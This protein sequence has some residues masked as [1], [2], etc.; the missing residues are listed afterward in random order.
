MSTSKVGTLT[1]G[2]HLERSEAE[3]K[4]LLRD[5]TPTTHYLLSALRRFLDK[6]RMTMLHT[7]ATHHYRCG[8]TNIQNYTHNFFSL[9]DIL[10]LVFWGIVRNMYNEILW[11]WGIVL[12]GAHDGIS[13]TIEH[14]ILA[15]VVVT[16]QAERNPIKTK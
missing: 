13:N 1:V 16:L 3:S 4:D 10:P 9:L 12:N 2:S 7:L 14:K 6:L 11:S 8:Y 5:I 15:I